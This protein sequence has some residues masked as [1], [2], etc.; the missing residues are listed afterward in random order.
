M[1]YL[2]YDGSVNGD[3]ISHYA[4]RFAANASAHDLTVLHVEDDIA[5]ADIEPK[6]ARIEAECATLD[7]RVRVE[8]LRRTGGVAETLGEAVRDGPDNV[9]IC[10]ARVRSRD[11]GYL[12]GTVSAELLR[13]RRCHVMAL[14]VVNPGLLGVPRNLLLPLGGSPAGLRAALPLLDLFAP[15]TDKLELFK[16]VEVNRYRYRF[17]NPE[18][19]RRMRRDGLAELTDAEAEIV[20]GTAIGANKIDAN[21]VV[22]DDWPREI[23]ITAGRHKSQLIL[24]EAAERDLR[25]KFVFGNRLEGMLRDAP[26]DIAVYRG[27]GD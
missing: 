3:W 6:L 21:A 5:V 2:A 18:R 15:N 25:Q 11:R 26:C 14:R 8:R 17:L 24:L 22:S 19:A 10:G 12:A 13:W 1:L 7:V 9:L 4:I 23:L 20:A 16:I 27:A